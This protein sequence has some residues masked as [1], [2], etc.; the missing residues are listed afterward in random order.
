MPQRHR[1]FKGERKK[2][3]RLPDLGLTTPPKRPQP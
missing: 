1:K 2:Q 3:D